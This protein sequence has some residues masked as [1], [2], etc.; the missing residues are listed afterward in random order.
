LNILDKE[1]LKLLQKITLNKDPF[2]KEFITYID[3]YYNGTSGESNFLAK[4]SNSNYRKFNFNK[5]TKE[6]EET[7]NFTFS[8]F[9]DLKLV[10]NN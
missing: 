2:K 4:K 6:Y 1:N 3:H 8:Y 10:G 9:N 7:G 5:L